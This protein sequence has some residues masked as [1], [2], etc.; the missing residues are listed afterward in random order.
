MTSAAFWVIVAQSSEVI[1]NSFRSS[2]AS[3][4]I[5]G[6]SESFLK[7]INRIQK[8][9][10]NNELNKKINRIFAT[11]NETFRNF[12]VG[13]FIEA[14]ASFCISGYS[15]SLRKNESFQSFKTGGILSVR[16]LNALIIS[17]ITIV[18]TI[19]IITI[20]LRNDN[21]FRYFGCCSM[22]DSSEFQTF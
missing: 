18:R 4:C 15:E 2:L 7:D 19:T 12:F 3:F 8:T 21:K 20:A 17:G 11:A 14:L 6:Y 22:L 1:S 5:S 13:Q 10:G 16:S 9:Y